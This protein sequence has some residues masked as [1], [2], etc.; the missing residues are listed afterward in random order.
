[1]WDEERVKQI[2]V[3]RIQM[4]NLAVR[5]AVHYGSNA[6][7]LQMFDHAILCLEAS[8]AGDMVTRIKEDC[9]F[10]LELSVIS[11]NQYLIDFQRRN[12]LRIEFLQSW[13]GGYL[14]IY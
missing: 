3:M 6:E 11:K 4:D 12:Y 5:L 14:D 10:H 2:G 1:C 8:K 7:F 9:A 13:R